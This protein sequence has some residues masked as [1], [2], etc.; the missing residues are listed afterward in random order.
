MKRSLLAAALVAAALL[1]CSG[2]FG[3]SL[4]DGANL[5][6]SIPDTATVKGENHYGCWEVF[7]AGGITP[8]SDTEMCGEKP[9]CLVVLPGERFKV[10]G[11]GEARF[12]PF[13]V[14]CEQECA[15]PI[16]GAP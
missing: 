8:E 9:T 16:M 11:V 2:S 6:C 4:S 14:A 3:A 7:A 15:Q 5:T 12:D 13:D 1:G 10:W